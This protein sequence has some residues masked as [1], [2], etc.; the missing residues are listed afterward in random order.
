MWICSRKILL[1]SI[2]ILALAGCGKKK[3]ETPAS[4]AAPVAATP[5]NTTDAGA[6]APVAVTPNKPID[7]TPV[8]KEIK[9]GNYDQAAQDLLALQRASAQMT[10]QQQAAL[11]DQMRNFQRALVGAVASGD[12]KAVA[13]A[14]RLRASASGA[15]Q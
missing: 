12:P 13:A 10:A 14:K 5:T 9:V 6:P 2:V 1:G 3:A 15:G 4:D 11:Q 7:W 8:Q